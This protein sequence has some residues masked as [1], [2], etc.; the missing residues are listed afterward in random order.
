MPTSSKVKFLPSPAKMY[1]SQMHDVISLL[2]T[3]THTSSFAMESLNLFVTT[4][5]FVKFKTKISLDLDL[6][7]IG[8]FPL[9]VT[10]VSF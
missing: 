9:L 5:S 1:S 10:V 6:F 2:C 3:L 7:M 4:Y 8:L